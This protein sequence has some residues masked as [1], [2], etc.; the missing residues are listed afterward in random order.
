VHQYKW[1]I[2][3]DNKSH[4]DQAIR[5]VLFINKKINDKII[6][7]YAVGALYRWRKED[8]F[9][10]IQFFRNGPGI[11]YKFSESII[12]ILVILLTVQIPVSTGHGQE[13]LLFNWSSTSIKIINM[14][15][16]NIL[17]FNS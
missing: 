17:T 7:S 9:S 12:L 11:D 13:F 4:N 3:I 14:Y 8:D 5:Y 10:G 1:Q 16:P 15:L 2:D 6:V